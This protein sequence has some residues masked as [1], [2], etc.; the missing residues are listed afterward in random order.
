MD[1]YADGTICVVTWSPDDA[2]AIGKVGSII[3]PA[4]QPP[5]PGTFEDCR[6]LPMQWL[7]STDREGYHPIAWMRPLEDPDK[8]V[9]EHVEKLLCEEIEQ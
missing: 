1:K 5:F 3:E 7:R 4:P 6:G 2:S 9:A 8:A